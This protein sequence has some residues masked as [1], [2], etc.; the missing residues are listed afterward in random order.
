MLHTILLLTLTPL[1]LALPARNPAH[2]RRDQISET[3]KSAVLPITGPITVEHFPPKIL[4]RHSH[5]NSKSIQSLHS[6]GTIV[7]NVLTL[8]AAKDKIN[9][10]P[11]ARGVNNDADL[12][13][14][15]DVIADNVAHI[16]QSRPGSER[17]VMIEGKSLQTERTAV[18]KECSQV[19]QEI[20]VLSGCQQHFLR[21]LLLGT[22]TL[23]QIYC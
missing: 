21:T 2:Y 23:A 7:G 22:M 14:P 16:A 5:A 11:M 19:A 8:T 4:P 17:A 12:G 10:D 20:K 1:S 3:A 13:D 6:V 9:H 15:L 18:E